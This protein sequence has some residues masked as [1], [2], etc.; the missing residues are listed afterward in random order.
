MHFAGRLAGVEFGLHG[1]KFASAAA[2][3]LGVT[4]IGDLDRVRAAKI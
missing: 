2:A 4:R 3:V 1:C